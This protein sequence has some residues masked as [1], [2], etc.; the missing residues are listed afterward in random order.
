MPCSVRLFRSPM[1]TAC[2]RNGASAL[3][4]L[5]LVGGGCSSGP[6]VSSDTAAIVN[7]VEIKISEVNKRFDAQLRQSPRAPSPEEASTFKLNILSQLIN[8]EI[9]MQRAAADDLTASDAEV[10]TRFTDFKKNY[11]EE[12]FQEFLKEQGGTEEEFKQSLRK[13]ATIEKLYNKE[14][15]SK[16]SVTEAEIEKHFEENKSNYNL[17]KGWRLAHI[18]ITDT[19][20]SGINNSRGDDATTPAEAQKKAQLLMRRLLNG[21]DFARLAVEYSED[22]ESAPRGGDLGFVT[23]QQMETVSPELKKTVQNLKVEQVFPRPI[24]IGYGYHLVKL[25][26][27]ERGGQHELSEPQVQ[28]DVRQTIFNRK[29]TL[30]KTAYLEIIRNDAKIRNVL[31]EKLLNSR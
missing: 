12:K 23:E 14:I 15:T 31:A 1:M 16:I 4:A 6:Q 7:Q 19:K 26:A 11:T 25:L 8:D 22:A 27:K 13:G 21:E 29:E 18:L 20:E 17:P 9:L 5:L 2:K 10:S 30:L 3:A 28:A 24:R